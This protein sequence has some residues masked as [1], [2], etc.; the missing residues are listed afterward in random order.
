MKTKLETFT[1]NENKNERYINF[2]RESKVY[3]IKVK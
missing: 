3:E 2:Y 1:K